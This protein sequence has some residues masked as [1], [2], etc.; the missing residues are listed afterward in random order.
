MGFNNILRRRWLSLYGQKKGETFFKISSFWVPQKNDHQ[1]RSQRGVQDGT[2][3]PWHLIGHPGC[4][5]KNKYAISFSLFNRTEKSVYFSLELKDV[6]VVF[7]ITLHRVYFQYLTRHTFIF[8]RSEKHRRAERT[9]TTS[10]WT[11]QSRKQRLSIQILLVLLR[12]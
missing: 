9:R 5:P 3:H 4:H 6:S 12:V 1:W 8:L 2:G 10:W 7:R 11:W